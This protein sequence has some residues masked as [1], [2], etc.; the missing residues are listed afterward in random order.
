MPTIN[1]ANITVEAVNLILFRFLIKYFGEEIIFY[2]FV[3][4][5]KRSLIAFY[6]VNKQFCACI[7]FFITTADGV[8][9]VWLV[10]TSALKKQMMRFIQRS[11]IQKSSPAKCC[12]DV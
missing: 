3:Q 9:S 6:T 4:Q 12:I 5:R 11:I 7:Y 2:L 8:F 1:N 10:I